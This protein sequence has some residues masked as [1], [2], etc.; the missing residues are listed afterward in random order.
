MLQSVLTFLKKNVLVV[1]FSV[2][3]TAALMKA[4][5]H[6]TVNRFQ[7]NPLTLQPTNEYVKDGVVHEVVKVREL[8]KEE[9]KVIT[10]SIRRNTKGKPQI[11]EVIRV[12]NTTDTVF[13]DL[14]VVIS[15]D[16]V[17]TSKVDSYVTARAIINTRT[18]Q[19]SIELKMRDT[20]T[21]TRTFK[22]H[23]FKS[24][25]QTIDITNKNPYNKIVAGS[26]IVVKEARSVVV[27][28]PGLTFNPVTRRLDWG[29][30]MTLNTFS[31]KARR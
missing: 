25:E 29:I 14:P 13:R 17:Q 19:G 2:L 10:D 16:T 21:Y 11:R 12:V 27:I 31:I 4:C 7:G 5:N 3:C 22:T 23:I 30:Q 1:A 26:A 6:P 15:G 20:L 28:G 9:M 24:D 8:T 18:K